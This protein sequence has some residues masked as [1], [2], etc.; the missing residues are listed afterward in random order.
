M[1]DK[2]R[3]V[4]VGERTYTVQPFKGFKAT[5]IG[6]IVAEVTKQ[7]P[8][9]TDAMAQFTREFESKNAVRITRNMSMLPRF[10]PLF[11]DMNMTEDDWQ[12]C[13][14]AVEIP[15]PP[16]PAM[17]YAAVFN[18]IFEQAED[19]VLNLL[20]WVAVT[21]SEL[22]DADEADNVDEVIAR[23]RRDLLHEGDLEELLELFIVGVDMIKEQ[24]TGKLEALTGAIGRLTGQQDTNSNASTASETDE[25][26]VSA[27]TTESQNLSTDSQP[28]TD[29][30]EVTP[31]I[32]P[33]SSS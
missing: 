24:F 8:G 17:V 4:Q 15:Q 31:S 30:P 29:G 33:T 32:E 23:I 16:D 22:R 28:R 25:A 26:P 6:R 21:N 14:G 7:V 19:K 2:A 13:G 11:E 27:T 10:K 18:L 20:A 12:R 1:S 5:R 3:T 9:V